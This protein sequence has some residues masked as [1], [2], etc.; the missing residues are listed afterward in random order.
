MHHYEYTRPLH[1]TPVNFHVALPN[2]STSVVNSIGLGL[3][4]RSGRF[5]HGPTGSGLGQGSTSQVGSNLCQGYAWPCGSITTISHCLDLT[6][7]SSICSP[8]HNDALGQL[9]PYPCTCASMSGTYDTTHHL[10]NL[11]SMGNFTSQL[12][13]L[14]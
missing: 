14:R 10:F 6:Y 9:S 3:G 1:S 4:N 7:E 11:H 12:Y 5:R 13:L 2:S 8:T